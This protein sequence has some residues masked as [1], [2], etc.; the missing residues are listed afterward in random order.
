MLYINE[1]LIKILNNLIYWGYSK[2]QPLTHISYSRK[3]GTLRSNVNK[4]IN[5]FN[6]R[7][8]LKIGIEIFLHGCILK[9]HNMLF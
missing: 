1:S 4:I 8:K 6:V 7:C 5:L 2:M 3:N 9:Y